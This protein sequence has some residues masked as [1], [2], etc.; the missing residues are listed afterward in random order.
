MGGGKYQAVSSG[1]SVHYRDDSGNLQ[2][3]DTNIENQS[4]DA[5]FNHENKKNSFKTRFKNKAKNNNLVKF[6]VGNRNIQF[7]LEDNADLGNVNNNSSNIS[8]N[9]VTYPN[10]YDGVDLKYTVSSI[11]LLEE[12]IV[13]TPQDAA[14]IN[15]LTEQFSISGVNYRQQPDGS[16]KFLDTQTNELVFTI[17]K[18]VMYELDNQTEQNFGL[19]YSIT[20]QGNR[21]YLTKILDAEGKSWLANTD[22]VYPIVIDASVGPSSGSTFGTDTSIGTANWLNTSNAANSDDSKTYTDSQGADCPTI[23]ENSIKLVNGGVI[24]G[25]DKSTAATLPWS[26]AYVSYGG[27]SDLWGLALTPTDVNGSNFGVGYSTTCSG[28][29]CPKIS[30]YLTATGFSFSVPANATVDGV[31]A[32]IEQ[33]MYGSGGPCIGHAAVDHIRTTVYYTEVA[34]STP[35][36]DSLTFTN[37]A[38]G[39]SNNAL[40]NNSTEANFRA[41]VSDT[42]GYTN[43]GSVVLRLANSSD[44]TT[45]FDA[46]KFTWDE[47]TDAFSET[48]DT[49]GAAT[50]TSNGTNSSC[51]S[52]TCTLDFKIK[53]NSSFAA[54]ATN[55]NAELLTTDDSAATDTDTYTDFYQ[56]VFPTLNFGGGINLQG[57]NIN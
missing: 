54:F 57:I 30:Y 49:Q 25:N 13:Q 46:L 14:K 41:V 5:N 45:P 56:V 2:D 10:V 17:P 34:N 20:Q 32:E 22:R 16:I 19:H 28:M 36:N 52:N 40:A 12:F 1:A 50:I 23:K 38:T 3:I 21:Y 47:A 53:F 37:P 8:G 42:D 24:S 6:E 4:E 51:S 31:I 26:D 48:A 44:S 7:G 29:S 33:F 9:T 35:T 55:Y 11:R 15:S 27:S 18:P 43:L 39:G